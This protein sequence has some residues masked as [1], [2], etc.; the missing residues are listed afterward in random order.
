MKIDFRSTTY[1][2]RLYS[3][4]GALEQ[5]ASEVDRLDARRA[6]VVCGRTVSRHTP[7]IARINGILGSCS[8]GTFDGLEKD[9]TLQSVLAATEAVRQSGADAVIAVGGGS[10]IQA[11]RVIL[12]LLAEKRPVEALMTQY[13][14]SG[15]AISPKLLTTKLPV[16]NVLTLPTAAQNRGGSA[17][18]GA[19][20]DHR[21]EFFDPKTRPRAI[22]WDSD[23]LLTAAPHLARSAGCTIYWRAVMNLGWVDV[24]P[25]IEGGRRHTVRL[26][27]RALQN[28]DAADPAPR[29]ELCTAA[30]L[31]NRDADE[32]GAGGERHW[33]A[34]VTYALAT[35]LLVCYPQI[36]HGEAFTALC[37]SMLRQLG[38]RDARAIGNLAEN[39]GAAASGMPLS[40]APAAAADYLEAVFSRLDMPTRVRDLDVPHDGLEKVMP[41]ALK[42][43]N[44]D[45]KRE[46]VREREFLYRVLQAAW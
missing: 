34:R 11:A 25:L 32:G 38:D 9:S 27:E 7:L 46:F 17:V 26:A 45:P 29:V 3:G 16:I 20:V 42:N 19:G 43:F 2:S 21:M 35:A 33:V 30:F 8:A 31:L 24:N 6:F 40:G 4:K 13:P 22:F 18:R 28:L 39:L 36:R 12:M 15:A 5:L 23:A 14:E 37:G 10:V 44:A 1:P 41:Y